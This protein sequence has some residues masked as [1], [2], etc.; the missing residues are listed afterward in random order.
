MALSGIIVFNTSIHPSQCHLFIHTVVPAHRNSKASRL[1]PAAHCWRLPSGPEYPSSSTAAGG[2]MASDCAPDSMGN[3]S[4]R[5]TA[6]RFVGAVTKPDSSRGRKFTARGA[7]VLIAVISTTE[8]CRKR[9]L[10]AYLDS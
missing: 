10:G 2:I 4:E 8:L 7:S 1:S 6:G 5:I 3:C 9:R